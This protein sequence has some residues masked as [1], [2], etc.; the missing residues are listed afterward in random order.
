MSAPVD[1]SPDFAIVGGTLN[2][3]QV[4]VLASKDLTHAELR[5]VRTQR[6]MP[7]FQA[8]RF[9]SRIFLTAEMKHYVI[10][11][12]DSYPD[13]FRKLFEIWSPATDPM[14]LAVAQMRE[15]GGAS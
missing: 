10:V 5:A 15:L 6:D 7:D 2:T 9:T 3:G 1:L 4:Q 8:P 14:E 13:A 12:A 11:I